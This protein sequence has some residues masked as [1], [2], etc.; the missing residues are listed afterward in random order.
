MAEYINKR[1]K[2]VLTLV[3]TSFIFHFS[4]SIISNG[5]LATIFPKENLKG[6]IMKKVYSSA[7]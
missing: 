7:C 5:I 1:R 2:N 4:K 6:L 3:V